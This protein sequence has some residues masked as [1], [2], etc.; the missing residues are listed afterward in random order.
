MSAS[1]SLR[2]GGQILL[3]AATL[4][5]CLCAQQ[6]PPSAQ[7]AAKVSAHDLAQRVDRHYNQLHSLKAGFVESYEGLG[8]RRTES[9]TLLLL[10]PGRMKWEYSVPAGKLFLLDG[11]YA[12]FYSRGDSQ[13]QRI[14]AKE[15]DDL[16]SPL[17][18]LL[19]HT[20]LEKELNSLTLAT[21]PNGQFTLSG[22]PKG[23]EKRVARLSLTVTADGTI[24]GIEI[25][26]ADGALTR[27]AFTGE[28]ANAPVPAET[29]NFTPPAGVPVVDA[30]PPV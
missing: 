13:V 14:A 19:G 22:Q 2:R 8:M 18:F 9:G 3:A 27:F 10:K 5:A 28:Q 12:W 16:R 15:L 11:K 4:S 25:E 17:R 21:A 29:F 23:Q 1:K 7:E 6:R 24:T 30:L 20:E 26:E